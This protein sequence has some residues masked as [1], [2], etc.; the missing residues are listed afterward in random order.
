M[1]ARQRQQQQAVAAEQAR[2]AQ[3]A[4]QQQ[5][6]LTM[7]QGSDRADP[8]EIAALQAALGG[9]LGDPARRQAGGLGFMGAE[10]GI[11]DG[12]GYTGGDFSGGAGWE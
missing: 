6:R 12:G 3:V 1:A 4:R 7:L 11:E 2:Q 9:Y 5:S 10:I 8:R